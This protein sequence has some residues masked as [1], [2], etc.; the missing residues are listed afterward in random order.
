MKKLVSVVIAGMIVTGCQSS[1]TAEQQVPVQQKEVT[2]EGPSV[3]EKTLIPDTEKLV[4]IDSNS[5]IIVPDNWDVTKKTP[6]EQNVETYIEFSFKGSTLFVLRGYTG[7]T[8]TKWDQDFE[9][10]L[11]KKLAVKQNII[12]SYMDTTEPSQEALED[13]VLLEETQKE[14]AKVEN[15][16]KTFQ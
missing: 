11:E 13:E 7:Y 15:V 1:Q 4:A 12:Y 10:G 5:S 9:G 16:V 8:E 14:W 6:S 2:T 3:P